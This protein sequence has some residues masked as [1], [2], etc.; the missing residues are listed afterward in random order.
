MTLPVDVAEAVAV[1]LGSPI[2]RVSSVG[3]GCIAHATRLD[4]DDGTFFL[5][6]GG[7]EV[8]RTFPAE[9][10]GL[11]ALRAADSPLVIP[12]VVA[13]EEEAG[14][15]PGFLLM[16]WIETGAEGEGFWEAFGRGL[17]AMHRHTAEQF[18]FVQDN[19][20]GRLP[21]RNAWAATWPA[22]FR[23]HRLGPQVQMARDRGRWQ[24]AWN[25][26]LESLYRRLDD[27]LPVQPLSSI[28][29]GDLW[30]GNYLVTATGQA[31]LIDPATYYGHREADL[32][33]SELF[34]GFPARFYQAYR[35][36]WPLA[37]GY[38]TRRAIY[39]LYH[40]INHLNHFGGG[41]AG[42]VASILERFA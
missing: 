13:A 35:E 39:N 42:S 21:Q 31:A 9:A 14:E 17:A 15:R 26:A 40:L 12:A 7:G 20:I 38:D 4:T 28:L 3:G 24:A 19:F 27:L 5:K 1:H 30:S 34:G 32:A 8:A 23:H 22:F 36:A 10:A 41:Y 33:M 25:R 11:R 2:R 18:G 37:P 16:E 29:H 6:Y